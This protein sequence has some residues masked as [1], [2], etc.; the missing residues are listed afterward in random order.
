[1][2][3]EEAEGEDGFG[4]YRLF[5]KEDLI[6]FVAINEAKRFSHIAPAFAEATDGQV[7]LYKEDPGSEAGT[8]IFIS[9]I[10]SKYGYLQELPFARFFQILNRLLKSKRRFAVKRSVVLQAILC[11]LKRCFTIVISDLNACTVFNQCGSNF[12]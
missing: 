8:T 5:L 9:L 12:V 2:Q 11:P 6:L 10:S 4:I 7:A 1:M 3:S